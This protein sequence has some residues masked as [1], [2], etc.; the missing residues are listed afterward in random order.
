MIIGRTPNFEPL[1]SIQDFA[2]FVD[3]LI[4]TCL[5]FRTGILL[6]NKVI[7]LASNPWPGGLSIF[8]MSPS[9]RVAQLYLQAQD[10]PFISYI[11]QGYGGSILTH[12]HMVMLHINSAVIHCCVYTNYHLL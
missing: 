7:S 11:L 12:L 2:R 9:N 5:D 1:P 4:F 8:F 6:Q 10:S 3:D